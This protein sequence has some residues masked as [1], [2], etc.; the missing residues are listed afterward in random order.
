MVVL[1]RTGVQYKVTCMYCSHGPV[2]MVAVPVVLTDTSLLL[3]S[4]THIQWHQTCYSRWNYWQYTRHCYTWAVWCVLY[5]CTHLLLIF[6]V[7]EWPE[8]SPRNQTLSLRP[9]ICQLCCLSLWSI[10][11]HTPGVARMWKQVS[12]LLRILWLRHNDSY[13]EEKLQRYYK[14]KCSLENH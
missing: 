12:T 5:T 10:V 9:L 1:I 13:T 8:A 6:T 14:G 7:V 11:P 3:R 4:T 2:V